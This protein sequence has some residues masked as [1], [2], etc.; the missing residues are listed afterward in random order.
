MRGTV[1]GSMQRLGAHTLPPNLHAVTGPGHLPPCNSAPL[2]PGEVDVL[3]TVVEALSRD[4][5]YGGILRYV[6]S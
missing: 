5:C 2:L 1:E 6:T 4:W 3:P